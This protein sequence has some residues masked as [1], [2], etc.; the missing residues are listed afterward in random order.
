MEKIR[1]LE[2]I[3]VGGMSTVWKAQDKLTGK[4]VAVKVLNRE[5]SNKLSEIEAFKNEEQ[6]MAELNHPNIAAA[7]DFSKDGDDWYFVMEYVDGYSFAEFLSRKMHVKEIDCLSICESVASALGYAWDEFGLVHCDLKP[8]NILVNQEGIIKVLD[9]G[10]AHQFQSTAEYVRGEHI[11]GTP[12][13]I[14]PEIVYGD[15]EPDCRA[16]IYSLGATLYH[17]ATGKMLFTDLESVDTMQAHC[18][19]SKQSPDPRNYRIELSEGFAQLLEAM[20]VKDRDYRIQTW[21]DVIEMAREVMKGTIFKPRE[22][23]AVSSIRLD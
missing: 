9:L 19:V 14:A 20:L 23:S 3:G 15:V 13:Y 7:Y 11:E 21:P 17:M 8:E 1:L 6:I 5:Y 22:S 16:D 4:I 2:K 18:D 12:A 10:I